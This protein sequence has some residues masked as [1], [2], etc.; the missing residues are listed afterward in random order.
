MEDIVEQMDGELQRGRVRFREDE[1]VGEQRN[2]RQRQ[3]LTR[4]EPFVQRVHLSMGNVKVYQGENGSQNR[5]LGPNSQFISLEELISNGSRH[6]TVMICFI[7]GISTASSETH[8]SQRSH[9]GNRGQTN[10]VRHSRKISIMC[11]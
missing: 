4:T 2:I 8:I 7:L 10:I 11:E 9:N 6:G 5:Q 3:P 1:D